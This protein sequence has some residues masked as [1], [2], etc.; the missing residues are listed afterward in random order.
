M[1]NENEDS[2]VRS[3]KIPLEDPLFP[4]RIF[5]AISRQRKI[6]LGQKN[7]F[8]EIA[9]EEYDELSRRLDRSLIQDAVAV[10]NVLR[11]RSLASALINDKGELSQELLAPAIQAFEQHLYSLGPH[12]QYD[13]KRQQ[14]ILKVLRLLRDDKEIWKF[15][16]A[17]SKPHAHRRAEQIIRET[18]ALPENAPIQDVD[19]RRA[20]LA[21]WLCTLRQSVGSCFATAPAIIVH[22]EQPIQ[23]LHD[24][25][26]LLSTGRLKRTFSGMEYS[27]PLSISWGAGDLKKKLAMR[28]EEGFEKSELWLSPGLLAAFEALGIVNKELPLKQKVENVKI[29]LRSLLRAAIEK[30]VPFLISAEEIVLQI[31]LRHLSIT[32]EEYVDFQHRPKTIA[33]SNLMMQAASQAS[34]HLGKGMALTQVE[35]L[36]EKCKSAFKQLADNALLKSWEFTLASFAETKA[37]FA[38]WNLYASLGLKADEPGGIGFAMYSVLKSRL[39]QCNRR[40]EEIQFEYEQMY[41]HVKY[42]ETRMQR[43]STEKELQWLKIEYQTQIHEFRTLEEMRDKLHHKSQRISGLFDVLVDAFLEFFPRYFQEVYDADMHEVSTGPY[44]DSPAGFRLLYKYG[45]SNT[46]QWAYIQNA[47]E[48]IEALHSFFIASET[49]ISSRQEFSHLEQELSEIITAITNQI[50]LPE[51]IET[52]F[53]RMAI[54]HKTP[55]VK[56]PLENL[57]KVDK[58]PWAYTSG[59]GMGTLVSSY[60]RLDGKPVE[61]SR[62]VENAMELLVFFIDTMKQIPPKLMDDFIKTGR[63]SLLIHSPTHAFLLKPL[64]PPFFDAWQNESF[65]YTFARDQLILPQVRRLDDTR[66]DTE[67]MAFIINQMLPLVPEDFRYYFNKSFAELTGEMTPP[68]FREKVMDIMEHDRGLR[69]QGQ[70]IMSTEE[71][72]SFLYQGIAAHS[73]PPLTRSL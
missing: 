32:R 3:I 17:I 20:A 16:R 38:T 2:L 11:T 5:T 52:A 66:L 43:A 62:W 37:D 26:E 27:V 57:E 19:A 10:R 64:T 71:I 49:E 42:L 59:G 51:F 68:E 73:T 40:I 9:S 69:L 67:G 45:R 15:L 70:T 29:T 31:L 65:S 53:E 18:L 35:P 61:V 72:D 55:L 14:H 34:S 50:R 47:Q 21:A 46:A 36:L 6:E 23:F 22:D 56:N 12:R 8:E 7:R 41:A 39:E 48:F 44:D 54:F 24:L 4:M 58:K 33:S 60:F 1:P 13:G 63:R 25:N 30:E 28:G